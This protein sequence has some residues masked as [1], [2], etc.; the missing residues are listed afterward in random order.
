MTKLSRP[1]AL[2]P[3]VVLSCAGAPE[4]D[5]NVVRSLGEC[6]VPVIVVSEYA[7]PPARMS[8]HCREFVQVPDFSAEP[9]RLLTAL[10]ALAQRHGGPLP[11]FPSADPDLEALNGLHDVAQSCVAWTLADP[12]LVTTLMD[13]RAFNDLAARTGL[14]VPRTLAPASL[15]EAEAAAP[16]LTY[17]V[18]VKP[19]H[20]TAW[21]HPEIPLSI[22]RSKAIQLDDAA[23]L[24]TLLRTVMPHSTAL[25]IQEYVPGDDDAH[26]DV[27][28]Y[29]D[30]Q[31]QAL[32][33]FSGRKWRI[34]PPHAG[35]GCFVESLHEPALEALALDIL[36]RVG[37]RGIANINFKRHARTGEYKL[38]EINA[39]VSQWNILTARAGVNL[40]LIAYR[41]VLGLPQQPLPRRQ[42]GMWYINGK[43]DFRAMRQYLRLGEWSPGGYLRS[44]L[45]RPLVCQVLDLGDPRPAL[46]LTAGWIAGKLG[47]R[48]S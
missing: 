34:Y 20:P 4:G 40:P 2:R 42:V 13:K 39:R 36:R 12:A 15:A 1:G 14:P 16:T 46:Q 24:V 38:L 25:L 29:I 27:H 19:S 44:L 11:V 26:F 30:R 28:A 41:D 43:N 5:L 9:Q 22:A 48:S 10:Q 23:A 18:I 31:G 6:G 45:R 8:R 17:P 35:S 21:R 47:R 3:A 32:A 33:T 37:Y 7:D